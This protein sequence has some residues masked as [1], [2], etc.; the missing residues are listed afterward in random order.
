MNEMFEKYIPFVVSTKYSGE[1]NKSPSAIN[2]NVVNPGNSISSS[3]RKVVR[4]ALSSGSL[5][6]GLDL[7]G[8]DMDIM[9]VFNNVHILQNVQH[10]NRSA[11]HSTL[12]IEEE[13]E[14]PGF[15]TLKLIAEGDIF[16]S[17]EYFVET[18]NGMYF[19]NM[20]FI[21]RFIELGGNLKQ[22]IFQ[23]A[24]DQ[25]YDDISI[26]L[27][28]LARNES[29]NRKLYPRP[30]FCLISKDHVPIA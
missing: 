14:F 24:T 9:L 16:T 26:V 22:L 11:R 29:E 1:V 28:A 21:G 15:T 17:P 18:T 20:S 25:V 23:V 3:I 12:L 4:R 30:H 6:E 5:A 8:S 19:S 2:F 27:L 10:M 13:M 7:P